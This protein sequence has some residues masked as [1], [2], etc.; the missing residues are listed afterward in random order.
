MYAFHISSKTLY[1]NKTP[2]F[3]EKGKYL[4]YNIRWVVGKYVITVAF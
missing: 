1:R 3:G 4:M 2:P